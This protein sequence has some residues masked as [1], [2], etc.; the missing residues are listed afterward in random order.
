MDSNGGYSLIYIYVLKLIESKITEDI[1]R[2][3]E[4]WRI[5]KYMAICEK[6]KRSKKKKK[7]DWAPGRWLRYMLSGFQASE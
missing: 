2:E 1:K 4:V 7:R 6:R 5:N 3:R